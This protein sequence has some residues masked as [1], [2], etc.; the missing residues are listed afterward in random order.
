MPLATVLL[1]AGGAAAASSPSADSVLENGFVYTVDPADHVAQALAVRDGRV[2][3][4]GTTGGVKRFVGPSTQVID[5]KGRMVMPGLVDGHMHPLAGGRLLIGCS[6]DYQPLTVPDFQNRIRACLADPRQPKPKGWLIVNSWF[7]EAMRPAGTVLDK[8]VL[9]AIAPDTPIMVQ[10][11]FF[12]SFLLNSAALK[13]AGITAATKAPAGGAILHDA[14]GAPTGL[15]EDTAA[16]LVNAVLPAPSDEDDVHAADAALRAMRHQGVTSFLDAWAEDPD[17]KAF[18]A[19]QRQGRLTARAHFAVWVDPKDA[20]DPAKVVAHLREQARSFD[21]GALGTTPGISVRNAKLFMDGVIAAPAL[22]G[23]EIDPYY[24][25]RGTVDHPDW[26]PGTSRGPAPYFPPAELAPLLR[27]IADAGFDPHMHADGDGAV[28]IALD[29]VAAVRKAEPGVDMRPAIAHDELVAPADRGR[30]KPLDAVAV[31]SFQWEKPAPDTIDS[32]RDYLG[33]ERFADMEPA[34]LLERTGTRIA[35]GSDWPVDKLDEWFA[36]KVGATRRNA[37]DSDPRYRGQLGAQ[38]PL[39]RPS[40]LRDITMNSSWE[41][42]SD[43]QTGSLESGKLADLIVL[44]RNVLRVPADDI[45]NTHVMLTM[46]GGHIVYSDG[47]VAPA[48]D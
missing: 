20:G 44:D 23:V 29:A 5:L 36:L 18:T 41:L 12:H 21:Q 38:P 11:S 33:P 14:Q 10:S 1:G 24:V 35:Y 37:P 16:T 17:L 3:Y 25:N 46:V 19:L 43:D 13:R 32:G 48:R 7:Q 9:D 45:A 4:V 6:L 27:A 30:Y 40:V 8:S 2:I 15:L 31:L 34:S 26:Q 28:R 47:R 39:S 42:R 22:T